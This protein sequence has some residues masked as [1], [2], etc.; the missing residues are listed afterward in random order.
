MR[1]FL[2]TEFTDLTEPNLLSIGLV[3]DDGHELYV[4]LELGTDDARD[5]MRVTSSFVHEVVL[6]QWG[7]VPG[8]ACGHREMG[9][10][11]GEWL[12]RLA[13]RSGQAELLSD[14][15]LDVEL[16][17]CA[18]GHGGVLHVMSK[19]GERSVVAAVYDH[20]DA[21]ALFERIASERGLQR[22]HALADA[23]ALRELTRRK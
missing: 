20:P 22:H 5:R 14:C 6:P 9:R 19:V 3:S 12:Q 18:L 4:E 16:L 17:E 15:R 11:A 10:R 7:R 21:D 2:D 8:A 1:V 23:L 13:E